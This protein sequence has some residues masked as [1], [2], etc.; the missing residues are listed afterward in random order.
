[1]AW[2]PVVHAVA[3]AEFGP[4]APSREVD[5]G[6]E[7]EERR[8]AVGPALEQ[9][10]VLPL[11]HLEPADAAA[12]H[13]A[14]P[15]GVRRGHLEPAGVHRDG[16]GRQRELDEA[17]A[18]LDFL[19]LHPGQRI[20]VLHFAG[21]AGGMAEGVEQGDGRDARLPGERVLPGDVGA[22]PERSPD[23]WVLK[24]MCYG[25]RARCTRPRCARRTR[26]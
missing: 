12:D 23:C 4:F 19:L 18:F 22:H 21:K 5:D 16:R 8:D 26:P 11:D 6:R 2:A 3:T 14:D 9:D 7:D 17:G 1:M 25:R 13:D 10:P 20:E 15:I 24:I